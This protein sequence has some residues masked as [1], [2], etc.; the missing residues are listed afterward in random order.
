MKK[1]TFILFGILTALV[2]NAQNLPNV[3]FENWTNEFLY[4]G[5][6][7][8]NSSNSMGS[9]DFSGIIQ[10]EDAYSGDYAIR[11]E[12]RLDGE[13]TI[14]NFIYHG[15][16][17][18]GPSGG[19]AYT[20]EFDQ[21][22]GYYK[23][24]MPDVDSATIY[25]IKWY[26]ATPSEIVSKVGGVHETWTEFTV[27]VPGGTCDSVFVGF[28]SSD[29]MLE[30]NIEFDSWVMF[31]S[32]YFNNTMGATPT[33]I[34]NHDMENWTDFEV[35]EVDDW[36]TINS[37]LYSLGI[38]HTVR[39]EDAYSGMYS[40]ELTG[41]DIFGDVIPGYLSLGE[42]TFDEGDPILPVPYTY[43]PTYLTG[44]YKYTPA[45]TDNAIVVCEMTLAGESVGGNYYGLP[46]AAEWTYFEIP[47]NYSDVPDECAL[48]F[49]SG[50]V[51]GSVLLLDDVDFDF[52]TAIN[53]EK[54]DEFSVYPNPAS[55]YT[56]LNLGNNIGN[57]VE[58]YDMQ[59]RIVD[60]ILIESSA[61][62]LDVMNCNSGVYL[63]KVNGNEQIIKFMVE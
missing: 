59:G 34:P 23:C 24:N 38:E 30:T 55:D 28:I 2:L 5:L 19:I 53:P 46:A 47:L 35:L 60:V 16:V 56:F 27:E 21:V 4:V 49:A 1:I 51:A 10:S 57:T 7:D 54:Q 33:P 48:V 43:Q 26:G 9:P 37:M 13:D 12:P 40:A 45:E 42:I 20:D 29:V 25:V 41:Y 6:D 32:V 61:V 18:D 22:K 63:V 52:S 14:F 58:I 17:T 62:K 50:E 36:Y 11:L 31:D 44:Y 8:W 15:T 3:G 39:S